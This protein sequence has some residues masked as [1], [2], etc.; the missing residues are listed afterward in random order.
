MTKL[1][2]AYTDEMFEGILKLKNIDE[3]YAFSPT[4]VRPVK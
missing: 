4:S 3:C 1:K 2:D